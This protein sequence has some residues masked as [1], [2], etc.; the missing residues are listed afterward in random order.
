MV[1]PFLAAITNADPPGYVSFSFARTCRYFCPFFSAKLFKLCHALNGDHWWKAI[2][3]SD[4]G[5]GF[6]WGQTNIIRLLVLNHSRV[7]LTVCVWS[8]SAPVSSVLQTGTGFVLGLFCIWLH[9]NTILTRFVVP[10]EKHPTATTT[11]LQCGDGVL[12]VLKSAR[13]LPKT[14]LCA[15]ANNWVLVSS[16]QR[17][18]FHMFAEPFIHFG[19]FQ[20]GFNLAFFV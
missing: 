7:T 20:M 2:L 12:R 3:K 13:C 16:E 10:D 4:L 9:L 8:T 11:M 19:K 14:T 1:E 5:L 18:F 15:K 17:T 6:E